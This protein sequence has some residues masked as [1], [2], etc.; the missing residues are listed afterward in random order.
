MTVP[1]PTTPTTHNSPDG[2]RAADDVVRLPRVRVRHGEQVLVD[3][4]DVHLEPGRPLSIVGESGSGKSLLAHALMGTLPADLDLQGTLEIGGATLPLADRDNRRALWGREL[5]LLPQEPSLALDP[6]MRVGRQVAEGLSPGTPRR[7]ERA[8]GALARLGLAG[9]ERL[10]PHTLSGG[11][12]QRVCLAAATVGGARVLVVDEPSK[13]LDHRSLDRLAALLTEHTAGGGLL[14]CITHDLSLARRLG[15]DT[16]VMR[17]AEI[18]ERGSV[19][20][21][22]DRPEHDYTRRLV[23][24]EPARW[25]RLWATTSGGA[26]LVTATGVTKAY[27]PTPLFADLDLTVRA[28][29]RWA[30]TGPSGAGKTTLGDVLLRLTPADAG[31]VAHD[32]SLAGARVQKLYQDPASSFP[33]RVPLGTALHDVVRRH[34]VESGRLDLLLQAVGLP[35]DLLTRRPGQVSGGELQRLAVVRA[36]LPRPRL[37]LADEA[38]SRLDLVSQQETVACLMDEVADTGCAL[39]VV[40]HDEALASAVAERRL[41]LAG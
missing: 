20:Q 40:T 41:D 12:A 5:A 23:A 29:E 31:T 28:G 38:T 1:T 19:E 35:S 18:V 33:A 36:M 27:G 9:T 7:T 24:A 14:L 2:R 22:L 4:A 26:D 3:V 15:G 11:M 25:G 10:F 17:E 32:P 30:L 13:G 21:V 8:L 37:V 6:T 16:L 39:V 34:R